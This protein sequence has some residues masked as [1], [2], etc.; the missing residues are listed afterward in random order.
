MPIELIL[1]T[2]NINKDFIQISYTFDLEGQF[3]HFTV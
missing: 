2:S 3:F 1:T